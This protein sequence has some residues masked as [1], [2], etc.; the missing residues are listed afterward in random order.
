MSEYKKLIDN[1]FDEMDSKMKKAR[2]TKDLIKFNREFEYKFY[3]RVIMEIAARELNGIAASSTFRNEKLNVL[4]PKIG[5][6]VNGRDVNIIGIYKGVPYSVTAS[7]RKFVSG[8]DREKQ[9]FTTE[10]KIYNTVFN[11]K[12]K[13]GDGVKEYEEELEAQLIDTAIFPFF[14][15]GMVQIRKTYSE[16]YVMSLVSDTVNNVRNYLEKT[17]R[18]VA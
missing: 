3:D 18:K 4:R 13:D 12:L 14:F 5:D 15:G 1:F 17:V 16:E 6:V 2:N 8:Y 7:R 10:T 9:K 11:I